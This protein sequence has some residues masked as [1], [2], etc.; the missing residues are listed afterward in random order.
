[1]QELI[2]LSTGPFSRPFHP[3]WVGGRSAVGLMI[4]SF[5][6]G[7]I[8][9]FATLV[10]E[11]A[12]SVIDGSLPNISADGHE[13]VPALRAVQLTVV[14]NVPITHEVG[15]RLSRTMMSIWMSDTFVRCRSCVWYVVVV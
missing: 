4:V 13:I 10:F 2:R 11:N 3:R 12:L 8:M 1:M 7:L 5:S 14:L 6:A 9:V 15:E